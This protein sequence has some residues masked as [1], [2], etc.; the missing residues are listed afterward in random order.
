MAFK[1]ELK[2]RMPRPRGGLETR[3]RECESEV[4]QEKQGTDSDK[5]LDGDKHEAQSCRV[6]AVRQGRG[7]L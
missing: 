4:K 2:V 7:G 5:C 6:R 3:R 1:L